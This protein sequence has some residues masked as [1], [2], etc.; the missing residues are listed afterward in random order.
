VGPAP[1][2][3]VVGS[4]HV[5]LVIATP[6]LP[7]WGDDLRPDVV[8]S[9]PGG[10]G[11]NQAVTL[12]RAGAH[13]TAVGVLGTDPMGSSLLATLA[14]E[15]IDVTA[16]ARRPAAPTPVCVVFTGPDGRNAFVWRLPTEYLITSD[17]IGGAEQAI[18]GADA[19]LLT[20]EAAEAIP[21]VCAIA[22]AA[23]TLLI[24]NPAP[25]PADARELGA[26]PWDLVDVLIPNEAEARALLPDDHPA[27]A[28][29]A[30]HLAEAVGRTL[31]VPLVCVTLAEHG[32]AVYD[33]V[34][35]RAYPAHATD[36]VD[37]TAAS[38]VFTAVFAVAHLTNADQAA[39]V[40]RAQ[41][42]AARTVTRPGAY[43]ALPTRSELRG[44]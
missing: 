25:A 6:R 27:R 3:V 35:T 39:A 21:P 13:V 17:V 12:A 34:T 29:P 14:G 42:A 19:V 41:S 38:D 11:L 15:G 4:Y 16:I 36:V 31:A 22:R 32:C 9:V 7:E 10:K 24:V 44:R 33:G 40:S 28:G 30:A 20:F 5:D 23:G 37:T 2:V 18:R 1:S 8:R 26:V 43:E